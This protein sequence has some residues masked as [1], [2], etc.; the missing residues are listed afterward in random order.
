MLNIIMSIKKPKENIIAKAEKRIINGPQ[1]DDQAMNGWKPIELHATPYESVLTACAGDLHPVAAF[2]LLDGVTG[3]KVWLR[4][5]EGPC[6]FELED[7][8]I[9]L[10]KKTGRYS[11]L[12]KTPTHFKKIGDM[13]LVTK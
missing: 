9:D 4:E 7:G 3:E 8:G 12:Y 1:K 13:P 2:Y 10:M 5:T 11:E 6:G